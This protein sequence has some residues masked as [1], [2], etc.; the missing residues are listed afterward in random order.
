MLIRFRVVIVLICCI[1]PVGCGTRSTVADR[2][3]SDSAQSGSPTEDLGEPSERTQTAD[4]GLIPAGSTR[5]HVFTIRNDGSA[6][7]L[8]KEIRTSCACTVASADHAVISPGESLHVA[9]RYQAPASSVDVL[10]RTIVTFDDPGPIVNLTLAGKVR[11]PIDVSEKRIEFRSTVGQGADPKGLI[12]SNYADR[13]FD[14]L[15][16]QAN[17]NWL[18]VGRTLQPPVPAKETQ[19]RQRWLVQLTP[20][21]NSL[22]CGYH[23]AL[24][25]F[26][27]V[28]H[29]PYASRAKLALCVAVLVEPQ[30]TATPPSLLFS[31][32][33]ATRLQ[34]K[35][36][37]LASPGRL[38]PHN[39]TAATVTVSESIRSDISIRAVGPPAMHLY[40][41]TLAPAPGVVT[42]SALRG[43]LLRSGAIQF[44]TGSNELESVTVPVFIYAGNT[45]SAWLP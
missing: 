16:C 36:I 45:A 6:D 1:A 43:S 7:W 20:D 22:P 15:R 28:S 11:L 18:R 10:R 21:S 14:D 12:V 24:V 26:E 33:S 9:I 42:Q 4:L 41:V 13:P 19:P 39:D 2:A 17:V 40:E 32:A 38:R 23:Q 34:S 29:L 31:S 5:H 27:E 30:I 37:R 8:L 35:K 3:I 44:R 25:S